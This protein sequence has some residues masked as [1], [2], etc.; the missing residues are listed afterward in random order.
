MGDTLI[1][2]SLI[3]VSWLLA[4]SSVATFAQPTEFNEPWKDPKVALAIDPFEGNAIDW[5]A[6]ATDPRV[7]A[8][9][10]RATMVI[11]STPNTLSARLK[12]R[13]A[14]TNGALIISESPVIR[15]N[16]QTSSSQL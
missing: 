8:I 12:R 2:R 10:H 4:L 14:V 6:L 13:S 11:V 1:V 5:D 15:S 3:F 9:I 7:V 16:R